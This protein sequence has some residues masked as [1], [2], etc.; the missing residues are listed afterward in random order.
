MS[1]LNHLQLCRCPSEIMRSY[2]E[3]SLESKASTALF[4]ILPTRPISGFVE[5][6]LGLTCRYHRYKVMMLCSHEA[7]KI[8]ALALSN[9]YILQTMCY[10]M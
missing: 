5:M 10:D 1:D 3:A 2:E 6:E 7:D 8:D 9:G 4:E